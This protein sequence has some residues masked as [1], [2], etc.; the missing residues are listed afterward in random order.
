MKLIEFKA[1]CK[2]KHTSAKY[3]FFLSSF[4]DR[5]H[6][7]C[8]EIT[9]ETVIESSIEEP[10]LQNEFSRNSN[11]QSPKHPIFIDFALYKIEL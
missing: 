9:K 1:I 2:F 4:K 6:F 5:I 3:L 7:N 8:T 10:C 11:L